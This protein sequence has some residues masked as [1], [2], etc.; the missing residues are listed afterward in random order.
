M[1]VPPSPA[2]SPVVPGSSPGT[3]CGCPRA[4]K[5]RGHPLAPRTPAP[6]SDLLHVH[7]LEIIALRNRSFK[8]HPNVAE[9][10][11]LLVARSGGTSKGHGKATGRQRRLISCASRGERLGPSNP[12]DTVCM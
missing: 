8:P 3:L 2:P 6:V 5:S 10:S 9:T 11:G 7:V 1:C 4:R 12:Q